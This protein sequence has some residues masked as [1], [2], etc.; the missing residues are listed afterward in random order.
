MD[1]DS[2]ARRLIKAKQDAK[3][4]EPITQ[5][6]PGIDIAGAYDIQLKIIEYEMKKKKRIIGKK[7]GLTSFGMQSLLNVNEPDY[8]H[9]L[10]DMMIQNR[11]RVRYGDLIYPKI[12]GEIAFV[13]REDLK[14]PDVSV[15]DVYKATEGIMPA[16]EIIDSRIAD[17]KIKI[18][19][20]IADN[21]SSALFVLGDRMH[22]IKDFDLLNI[23]MYI[24]KDGDLINS[25]A[26]IEVLDNP[27][28]SVAWLVNK[29]AEFGISLKAGEIILSGAITAAVDVNK[30]DVFRVSFDRLGTVEVGF[31]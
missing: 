4:I 3:P 6:I 16:I 7:I 21:A 15:T 14:G 31:I 25:G 23:G 26:G 5:I 29:L 2:I 18:E 30:N 19:D 11:S 24:T 13:L 20:T 12:E 28:A 1:L 27:V 8:G 10:N 22:N 9:L 17:W